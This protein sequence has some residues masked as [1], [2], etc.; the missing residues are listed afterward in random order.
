MR[1]KSSLLV[2]MRSGVTLAMLLV[3]GRL[4]SAAEPIPAPEPSFTQ[5]DSSQEAAQVADQP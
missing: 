2:G 4:A 3:V 1:H 5:F